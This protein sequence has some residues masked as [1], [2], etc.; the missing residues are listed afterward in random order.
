MYSVVVRQLDILHSTKDSSLPYF[1]YSLAP[2]IVITILLTIFPMPYFTS[3]WWFCNYQS[4]SQ[5]IPQPHVGMEGRGGRVL[6]AWIRRNKTPGVVV[7]WTHKRA[8]GIAFFLAE[9]HANVPGGH[10]STSSNP[11]CSLL[12]LRDGVR[13]VGSWRLEQLFTFS[14]GEDT[15][16][17]A[18][19]GQ[20]WF[21]AFSTAC[22]ST[23]H[24]NLGCRRR[25]PSP[26]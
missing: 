16:F 13:V 12:R 7:S 14:S 3:P 21:T 26:P 5:P 19:R 9:V 2:C 20:F 23:S 24:R 8:K 22:K 4:T 15:T 17:P 1:Q 11:I 10:P 25:C 6:W 18:P